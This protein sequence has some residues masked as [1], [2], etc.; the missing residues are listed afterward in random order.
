[1]T[2]EKR[3]HNVFFNT[4]TVSG[5]VI[6]VALYIIFFAGA[7][8]IF[9]ETIDDWEFGTE[10]IKETHFNIDY[11]RIV[12]TLLVNGYE[13]SKGS[14]RIDA[15]EDELVP[16]I[17]TIVTA[18]KAKDSVSNGRDFLK[19]DP[20][21]YAF[22][23]EARVSN[24]G[25]GNF[26]YRLH[27]LQQ[28][29]VV[30]IYLSGL[31]ALFFLFAIVTGIIVHWKKMVS[32]FFVFRPWEKIKTIWTD[33][34]TVLGVI[35]IPF[36]FIYAVTG[37]FYGISLLLLIPSAFALFD[38]DQ[39]KLINTVSPEN[40][41]YEP[42][43]TTA[44]MIP[45]GKIINAVTEKGELVNYMDIRVEISNYGDE[46]A[47]VKAS[48]NINDT[49]KDFLGDVNY[50]YKLTDGSLLYEDSGTENEYNVSLRRVFGKLHFATY[51]GY[52]LK[53]IYFLLAIITC[54]VI[55]TGVLIWLKAR[56]K[57]NNT[58]KQ[59]RFHNRVG[60]SYMGI[61]L[62]IF[63]ATALLFVLAK[64]IPVSEA[65]IDLV[66]YVF[67]TF[68]TLFI[69]YALIVKSTFKINK[70]ALIITSVFGILIPLLNGFMTNAWL[71]N[72]FLKGHYAAFTVDVFWLVIGV[73][74]LAIA[75]K[76]KDK[77]IENAKITNERSKDETLIST[78]LNSELITNTN[79][80]I[81]MRVKIIILWI[82]IAIGFVF[83]HIYG[84]AT[85]FFNESVF[86]E[87]STG[88]T[89][90]W[91]HQWRIIMEGLAL[92]FGLLTIEVAKKGFRWASFVWA[93]LLGAFN[94]YHI[95]TATLYEA[96][97]FSELLIL[98]LLVV[99]SVFLVINL[100]KWV[101]SED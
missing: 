79:T 32:N 53:I 97:N 16:Y 24:S 44:E 54:F 60:A 85:V 48:G 25:I 12:D 38:G 29:P 2:K 90:M 62:G 6:S 57:K 67:F 69:V 18:K 45:I 39:Q 22:K 59:I 52:P 76:L 50:V 55:I 82:F 49:K 83:H 47:V 15:M 42:I 75:L 23:E 40:I 21:T 28:I 100:W 31:V 98:G 68:W 46:N 99:A 72:S 95:V 71:W 20:E 4:H 80:T 65:K 33:A 3:N 27:F 61:C 64:V 1:M 11:D 77:T 56:D 74:C 7:F 34:H 91:A 8:T 51:G 13:L 81:K 30:G 9:E 19:F 26:I 36:Q 10:A 5:I 43:G 78:N 37:A 73:I 96:T 66:S 87:G 17:R 93:V 94:V 70:V 14:V 88:E 92:F 89:P 58:V 63:P 84:L 86:I 41:V 101:K 35:G